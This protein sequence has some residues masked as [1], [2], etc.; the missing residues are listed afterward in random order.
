MIKQP[1]QLINIGF[2]MKESLN[3]VIEKLRKAMDLLD[4]GDT[5]E[6]EDAI[7]QAMGMVEF[8]RDHEAN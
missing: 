1:S 6:A 2:N 7:Y 3:E 8:I 5:D 4:R